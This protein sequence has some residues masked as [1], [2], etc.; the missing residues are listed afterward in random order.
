VS[1]IAARIASAS[2]ETFSPRSFGLLAMSS[3]SGAST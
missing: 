3:R 2:L 1:A